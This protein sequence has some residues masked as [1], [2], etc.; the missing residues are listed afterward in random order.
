VKKTT[1]SISLILLVGSIFS[2]VGFSMGQTMPSTTND[3]Y[4]VNEDNILSVNSQQGVLKNDS[5]ADGNAITAIIVSGGSFGIL[6]LNPDGS[7]T[8]TPFLNFNGRDTFTYVANNSILNSTQATVNIT[9]NPVNDIPIASNDY[10]SVN[11]DNT[12]TIA[13]PGILLN[14][15]DSDGNTLT[16]SLVTNVIH[17]TLLLN[18]NGGFS[19]TPNSNFNGMD[20]FK[21]NASDGSTNSNTATVAIKVNSR[22]DIPVASSDLYSV[23]ENQTLVIA[24]PGILSN[25]TDSDSN[26]LIASIVTNVNHGTLTLN[27]NGSFTYKPVSNFN[28]ID[29][30]TYDANDGST[31]SNAATVTIKINPA[32]IPPTDDIVQKLLDQIQNLL[33]RMTGL[34]KDVTT[35]KEK[36]NALESR[37][38]LLESMIDGTQNNNDDEDNDEEDDND[39]HHGH[40]QKHDDGED[41]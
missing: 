40:N 12:L 35:L 8:Y 30:F 22:N 16:T 23:N 19:Y 33:N 27:P 6:T 37:V 2:P 34:E 41:D 29:S 3:S 17:G 7:F 10:Y 25:D 24:A 18:S 21:Y 11:E 31:N 26:A 13:N 1:T 20:S 32:N 9:I 5:D 4:S 14:D 39:E 38:L 36:N 15:T 28:G